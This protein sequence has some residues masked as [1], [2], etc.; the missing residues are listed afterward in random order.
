MALFR[1]FVIS[2]TDYDK[3]CEQICALGLEIL[4]ND[5]EK[6]RRHLRG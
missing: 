5:D 6:M 2:S 4:N 1:A 3:T